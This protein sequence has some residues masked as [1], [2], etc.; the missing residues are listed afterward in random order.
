MDFD[1]DKVQHLIDKTNDHLEII[2]HCVF[3]VDHPDFKHRPVA[4]VAE[5]H[6]PDGRI[7]YQQLYRLS[8]EKALQLG[9]ALLDHYQYLNDVDNT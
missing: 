3:V 1:T 9:Q 8:S 7:T 2:D 5:I 4:L 6:F